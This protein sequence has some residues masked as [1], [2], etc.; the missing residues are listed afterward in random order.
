MQTLIV[1]LLKT[2]F[3]API[4]D[5]ENSTGNKWVSDQTWPPKQMKTML[6]SP[7]MAKSKSNPNLPLVSLVRGKDRIMVMLNFAIFEWFIYLLS[8]KRPS[9]RFKTKSKTPEKK[10]SKK[11]T[12]EEQ[13]KGSLVGGSKAASLLQR[14]KRPRIC[15]RLVI[16]CRSNPGMFVFVHVYNSALLFF[17]CTKQF[18][19]KIPGTIFRGPTLFWPIGGSLL[20]NI[21]PEKVF[22]SF[23]S[24]SRMANYFKF[25]A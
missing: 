19:K 14:Q 9:I 16:N 2:H 13:K 8:Y 1:H 15:L 11:A 3:F 18:K 12:K 23:K 5:C 4:F 21:S 24:C 20:L 22:T 25:L 10:K 7:L 17:V 6:K